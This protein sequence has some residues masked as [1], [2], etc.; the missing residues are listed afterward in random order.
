MPESILYLCYYI[1]IVFNKQVQ[2]L[3]HTYIKIY[4][5]YIVLMHVSANIA[6]RQSQP[7]T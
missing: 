5:Q 1:T 7:R 6:H 2:T 3:S 4:I